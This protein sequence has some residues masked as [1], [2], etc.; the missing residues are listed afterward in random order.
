MWK[1]I[2]G[3]LIDDSGVY[4]DPITYARRK[5]SVLR[6]N[7]AVTEQEEVREESLFFDYKVIPTFEIVRADIIGRDMVRFL[8]LM[9]VDA[10]LG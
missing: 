4:H 9:R 3:K 2:E 5:R 10:L 8:R 6:L 1:S 7:E